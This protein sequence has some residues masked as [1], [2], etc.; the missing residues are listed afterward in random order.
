MG[1]LSSI[2][3]SIEALLLPGMTSQGKTDALDRM[4]AS[5]GEKLDWRHSIVDLMKLTKMDS[6]VG[7]RA[8]LANELG[9]SGSYI[10]TAEQNLWLHQ[11]VMDHLK[12]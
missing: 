8:K 9:Y 2:I 12:I 11:K 5:A 3:A 10:G 4:A 6:S 7:A 1:V